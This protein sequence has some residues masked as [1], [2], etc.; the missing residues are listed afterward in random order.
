MLKKKPTFNEDATLRGAWRRVFARSPIV[1]EVLMEGRRTVPRYTKSGERHKVD[2]V[3]YLCQTCNEWKPAKMIEVDHVVPVIDIENISGK[4][5]DWNEFKRRLFCPKSNLKRICANCHD[6]KTRL[7]RMKRQALKDKVILD[8][9]EE[10][11]K[12]T[13]SIKEEKE[14]KKQVNKFLSK[15]KAPETRERAQKLKQIILNKLKE[16]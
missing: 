14:L 8:Q 11:L 2:A 5:Q 9:L 10:R 4:V 12:S 15:T 16:D 7:E 1:R 13:W 3:E 6:S